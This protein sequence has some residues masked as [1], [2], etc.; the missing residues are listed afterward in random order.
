MQLD[1]R[2]AIPTQPYL[3]ELSIPAEVADE[4]VAG[5][6]LQLDLPQGKVSDWRKAELAKRDAEK[7]KKRQKRLREG[8]C[9]LSGRRKRASQ[10]EAAVGSVQCALMFSQCFAHA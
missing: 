2:D 4:R 1:P 6:L 10:G 8:D 7:D 5:K 3:Q 9:G